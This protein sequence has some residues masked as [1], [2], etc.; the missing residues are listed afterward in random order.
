VDYT[1]LKV[2]HVS[3]VTVSFCGF[4]ARGIGVLQGAPWVRHRAT[5]RLADL[6]DTVLLLSAVGMLAVIHVWPWALPWLRAKIVG[7]VVYVALGVVALRPTR[8]GSDPRRMRIRFLFWVGALLVF[9]YIVSV[10]MTKSPRG[11]L[12]GLEPAPL[13][14]GRWR[15]ASWQPEAV[16]RVGVLSKDFSQL[17]LGAAFQRTLEYAD[18]TRH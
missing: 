1:A 4:V 17:L 2:L 6:V 8:L 12:M 11:A 5:R 10:A 15:D 3:A 18:P 7:L 13:V 9:G 16:Q 14:S